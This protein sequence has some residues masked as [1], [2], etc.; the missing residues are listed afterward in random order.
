MMPGWLR[1]IR[2]A[3]QD[4]PNHQPKDEPAT[5]CHERSQPCAGNCLTDTHDGGEHYRAK[6]DD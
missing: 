2:L 3:L 5:C 4:S 1:L 6:D